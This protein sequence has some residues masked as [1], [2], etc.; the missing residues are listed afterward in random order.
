MGT[1]FA[2]PYACLTVGYLEETKLEITVL[3]RYF[4]PDDCT[5]ILKLLLRYI[6]DGFVP[7]PRRL[8]VN[9]FFEAIN[10][11]YPSLRFT[12]EKAKTAIRNGQTV[13]IL[14]FL[15]VLIILY[16]SGKVSTDN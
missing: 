2:P 12:I 16:L 15:D 11:L 13:Q 6:D 9:K 8:D 7:W 1:V 14:N 5:L 10:R 3:P 4:A